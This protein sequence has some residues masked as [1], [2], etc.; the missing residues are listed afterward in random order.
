MTRAKHKPMSSHFCVVVDVSVL[1][2][3]SQPLRISASAHFDFV[4]VAIV[5]ISI[6]VDHTA[7]RPTL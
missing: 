2:M 4:A 3:S 5:V 6:V 7:S 1:E